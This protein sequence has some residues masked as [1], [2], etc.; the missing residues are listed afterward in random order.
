M[1]G[2]AGCTR[3]MVRAGAAGRGRGRRYALARAYI[4]L[5]HS[6]LRLT[7][8]CT[9]HEF[10]GNNCMNSSIFHCKRTMNSYMNEF[11]YSMKF[12]HICIHI[13]YEF[14]YS[15]TKKIGEGIRDSGRD[16]NTY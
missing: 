14:I 13:F 4:A 1:M 10:I 2:A 9:P 16:P 3:L 12:I 6:Q 15:K 7:L 11:I 8:S 5:A